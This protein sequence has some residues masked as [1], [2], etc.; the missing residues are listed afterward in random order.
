M[1]DEE[2]TEETP[3]EETITAADYVAELEK[4]RSGMVSKQEYERI[5]KENKTLA[6]SLAR[7]GG[8]KPE[9][10]RI[11]PDRIKE[12]RNK[13]Y[14]SDP[15]YRNNMDFFSDLLELR[16]GVIETEGIDPF[17]PHNKNYVPSEADEAK[18]DYIAQQIGECLEYADGD[19]HVFNVEIQR[20]CGESNKKYRR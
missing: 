13:L 8:M 2:R 1:A 18:A 14:G 10:K 20:R 15:H 5:L 7:G 16:Q 12:L 9:E 11:S 3:K 17:L 6:D 19:P 4:I